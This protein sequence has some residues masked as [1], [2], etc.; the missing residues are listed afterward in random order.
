[1]NY[2]WW[3]SK[4]LSNY[5]LFFK[6]FIFEIYYYQ[7]FYLIL[8][9]LVKTQIISKS[10]SWKMHPSSWKCLIWKLVL[11]IWSNCKFSIHLFWIFLDILRDENLSDYVFSIL[12]YI[13]G[14]FHI[15]SFCPY[16]FPYPFNTYV[17][18]CEAKKKNQKQNL[19]ILTLSLK[20]IC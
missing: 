14:V 2:E 7:C 8:C 19:N 11:Y 12:C 20:F 16:P 6:I 13:F 9:K 4:T 17:Q 10:I 1:M 3:V 18:K 5:N 15:N